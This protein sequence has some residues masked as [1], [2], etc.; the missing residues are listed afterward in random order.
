MTATD[1]QAYMA[2]VGAAA[3]AAATAMAAASTAARNGAL[4]R[5]ADLIREQGDS[6]KAAN[7]QDVAAAE[8]NGLAAP[9]VD[10]LRITDKVVAQMAENCVQVA[11]EKMRSSCL[12]PLRSMESRLLPPACFTRPAEGQSSPWSAITPQPHSLKL[13]QV[14]VC[15]SK[16]SE[17]QLQPFS[18]LRFL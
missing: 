14:R 9:M 16:S 8:R 4:L 18:M 13:P 6:L 10:R 17:S 3:R 12:S 7:A 2:H 15:R 5:L 1:I 11:S